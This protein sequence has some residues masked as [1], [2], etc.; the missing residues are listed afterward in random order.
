[1][2]PALAEILVPSVSERRPRPLVA[3]EASGADIIEFFKSLK[4]LKTTSP[5]TVGQVF[6]GFQLAHPIDKIGLYELLQSY[7]QGRFGELSSDEG[8]ALAKWKPFA[9]HYIEHDFDHTEMY[10]NLVAMSQVAENVSKPEP[11]TPTAVTELN[12]VPPTLT[13]EGPHPEA[14]TS[15]RTPHRTQVHLREE[16]FNELVRELDALKHP[17]AISVPIVMKRFQEQR[18]PSHAAM[19]LYL[20]QFKERY[21][22]SG[23][24][25]R[26]LPAWFSKAMKYMKTEF[27]TLRDELNTTELTQFKSFRTDGKGKVF[28]GE[29][30]TSGMTSPCLLYTSPSPRDH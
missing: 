19:M 2:P 16:A 15:G 14:S 27:H 3:K 29:I 10:R 22:S 21:S 13:L 23:V 4:S 25:A 28:R 9:E 6:S 18:N 1:M 20:T 24:S 5:S 7:A 17:T 26:P 12:A 30:D 8:E 11:L